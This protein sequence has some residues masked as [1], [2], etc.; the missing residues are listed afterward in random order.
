MPATS[1]C[2]R[3]LAALAAWRLQTAGCSL[4]L[5][6]VGCLPFT[7]SAHPMAMFFLRQGLKAPLVISPTFLP[8]AVSTCSGG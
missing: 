5:G 3:R 7:A 2:Q 6:S 4:L 1:C 8:S